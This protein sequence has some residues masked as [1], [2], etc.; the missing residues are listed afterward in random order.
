MDAAPVCG[1]WRH[2]REGRLRDARAP[3]A[4][5]KGRWTCMVTSMSAPLHGNT[6]EWRGTCPPSPVGA[7]GV[8]EDG[9]MPGTHEM[10]LTRTVESG[11]EEWSCLSCDRRMLLRW[12]PRYEKV[13]LEPGD[14][15]SPTSAARAESGWAPWRPRRHRSR[16][17][18]ATCGGCGTTASTGTT[19]RRESGGIPV[20]RG[21]PQFAGT[22]SI[23]PSAVAARPPACSVPGSRRPTT[24]SRR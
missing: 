18:S 14:E 4:V 7:R 5:R 8:E 1:S 13:V 12:P 11:A 9:A 19:R 20:A 10:V 23:R 16:W 3:S 22:S 2:R 17:P 15:D 21:S 6:G 24:A